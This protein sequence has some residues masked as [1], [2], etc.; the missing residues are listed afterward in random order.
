[1]YINIKLLKQKGYNSI[2][3]LFLQL[4]NQNKM[5]DVSEEIALIYD[6]VI[7]YLPI[8]D[9]VYTIKGTKKQNVFQKMRL[10]RKGKELIDNLTTPDIIEEDITI[11][12]WLKNFY[13]END[14]IIGNK[15]QIKKGIAGFRAESQITKNKL[16]F[17]L[18]I[19]LSDEDNMK[20][21]NKLENV[22]FDNKNLYSKKFYIDSCR[23]YQY[24]L[25]NKYF[26]DNKFLEL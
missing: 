11:Y 26:F 21:N 24:Y 2:D 23:L 3:L 19:F 7:D 4:I 17:L 13:I 16:A 15:R 20:Y 12:E 9:L 14:K 1:M 8:D 22:F 18:K 25:K 10:T 6:K 5:E